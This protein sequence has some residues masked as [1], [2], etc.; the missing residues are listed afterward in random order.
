MTPANSWA[1]N[2]FH[3]RALIVVA[4][5]P[6]DLLTD[7]RTAGGLKATHERTAPNV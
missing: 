1:Q 4:P 6:A 5:H 3:D 7:L 2:R